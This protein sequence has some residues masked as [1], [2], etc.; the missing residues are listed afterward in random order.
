MSATY[1]FLPSRNVFGEGSVAQAGEL[2]KSLNVSKPL[3]VTDAFLAW[4]SA[5][6]RSL[7]HLECPV[8]FLEVQSQTR[9]IKMWRLV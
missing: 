3:I 9:R 2:L 5:W 4:Q 1:Y 6:S 8:L 7:R